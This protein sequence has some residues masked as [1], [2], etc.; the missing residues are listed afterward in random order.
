MHAFGAAAQ[1]SGGLRTAQQQFA[2]NRGLW[3]SEIKSIS[4]AMLVF[5]NAAIAASRPRKH[6]VA[7]RSQSLAN[8]VFFQIHQRIAIGFLVARMDQ[9]I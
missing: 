4:E 7:E 6:L 9:G 2:Q 5:C 8:G 3:S 1:F